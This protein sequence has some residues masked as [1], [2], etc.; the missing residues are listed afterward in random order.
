MKIVYWVILCN[1]LLLLGLIL[2]IIYAKQFEPSIAGLFMPPATPPYPTAGLLTHTFQ[3]FCCIAPVVCLFSFCLLNHLNPQNKNNRFILGSA[4]ITGGFALN[5]IYRIHII[6][7]Y[8]YPSKYLF[9]KIYAVILLL[10]I[11]IFFNYFKSTPYGIII[12]SIVLLG[13]AI[14]VDSLHLGLGVFSSLLEGIPKLFS[15]LNLA[16][17][18]WLVC[19]QELLSII[20]SK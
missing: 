12:V 19:Y 11:L 5:E 18:F 6:S 9:I 16:L 14:A 13:F 7:Q 1:V 20:E 2:L 8:F 4:L 3:I 15:G 17:Y 10:Y